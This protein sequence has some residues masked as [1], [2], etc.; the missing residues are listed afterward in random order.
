MATEGIDKLKELSQDL[1]K[2]LGDKA[3]DTVNDKLAG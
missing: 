3:L 2:N 1:I